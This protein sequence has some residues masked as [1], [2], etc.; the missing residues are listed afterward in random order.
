MTFDLIY[1]AHLIQHSPVNSPK[2]LELSGVGNPH[3]LSD[4]GIDVNIDLPGVGENMQ[5]HTALLTTFELQPD[6]PVDSF[7]VFD[8]QAHRK[9]AEET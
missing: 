1:F 3:I 8:D 5:D 9:L 7:D 6:A 2:I 4:I